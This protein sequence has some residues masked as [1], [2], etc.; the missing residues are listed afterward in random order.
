MEI[1]EITTCDNCGVEVGLD[2]SHAPDSGVLCPE[3]VGLA[4][5]FTGSVS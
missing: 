2:S 5:G 4:G 3:C 1:L